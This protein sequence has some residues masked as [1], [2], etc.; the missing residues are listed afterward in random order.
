MLASANFILYF[1]GATWSITTPGQGTSIQKASD[2]AGTGTSLANTTIVFTVETVDGSV[3][4]QQGSATAGSVYSPPDTG[5]W[6]KT[7]SPPAGAPYNSL[8][9]LGGAAAA[10]YDGTT[11]KDVNGITFIN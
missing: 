10:L 2:V 5:L 11:Q 8:W 6:S 3:V 7:L 9:P 4:H 1:C